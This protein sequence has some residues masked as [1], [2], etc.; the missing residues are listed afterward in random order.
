MYEASMNTGPLNI[1]PAYPGPLNSAE[2]ISDRGAT[3]FRP[4]GSACANKPGQNDDALNRMLRRNC[5]LAV[6]VPMDLRITFHFS[7]SFFSVY[8]YTFQLYIL[9]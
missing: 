1:G 2:G 7:S 4:L 5:V 9:H 8:L 3:S 6:G